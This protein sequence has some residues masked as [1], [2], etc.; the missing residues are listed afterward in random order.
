M[1]KKNLKE[2]FVIAKLTKSSHFTTGQPRAETAMEKTSRVV[3]EITEQEEDK[4]QEKIA[5]LRKARH[6]SEAENATR[7]N[8]TKPLSLK[9]RT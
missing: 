8:D 7:A 3:K 4:R 6:E 1:I 9:K 5:R 2:S